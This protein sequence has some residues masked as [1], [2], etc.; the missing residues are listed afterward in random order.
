MTTII[1]LFQDVAAQGPSPLFW[2]FMLIGLAIFY[3]FIIRPQQKEQ[4]KQKGFTESLK[5]GSKV[6][7]I[8]G[9]H[10]TITDL[11]ETQVSILIAPKTV[12]NI[13]RSCISL[14]LSQAVYG[15]KETSKSKS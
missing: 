4:Q 8:G 1:Y 6:V 9:L 10:G 5:K 15:A 11:D 14:E 12:V 2:P 3:F 13:Q 7:T